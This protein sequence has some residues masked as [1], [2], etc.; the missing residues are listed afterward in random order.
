MDRALAIRATSARAIL[1]KGILAEYDDDLEKA[2]ECYEQASL[3][4]PADGGALAHLGGLRWSQDDKSLGLKLVE[5]AFVLSPTD[6]DI[7]ARFKDMATQA[8]KLDLL[9]RRLE[10]AS[11]FHPKH[12]GIASTLADVHAAVGNYRAAFDDL[13]RSLTNFD[14]EENVLQYGKELRQHL[15]TTPDKKRKPMLSVCMIVKNEERNLVRSLSSIEPI[16]DEIIVVDTGSIDRTKAVSAFFGAAIYETPWVD[17]FSAARN[18]SL[19]QARGQ[20]ILVLDADEVI[21]ESD[22]ETLRTI[23]GKKSTKKTAYMIQTRDYLAAEDGDAWKR[24]EGEYPEERGAGWIPGGKVRLFP[25]DSR[26]RFR[27]KVH[28]SVE[29]SLQDAEIPVKECSVVIHH[30]GRLDALAVPEK[31][32][33]S[34]EIARLKLKESGGKD[35]VLVSALARQEQESQQFEEA[36]PLWE[37]YATLRPSDVEGWLGTGICRSRLGKY[38]DAIPTLRKVLGIDPT[39]REGN[40]ELAQAYLHA[41]RTGDAVVLLEEYCD[42]EKTFHFAHIVLAA[43]YLC[44]GREAKAQRVMRL[45][46]EQGVA[47][48]QYLREL[49]N[50]FERE[51][52][53]SYAEALDSAVFLFQNTKRW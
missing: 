43:A 20:W 34:L 23:V 18:I 53:N 14:I 44:H 39:S 22:Y 37:Q 32:T 35:P 15:T 49:A 47:Y 29:E 11:V 9:A 51:G 6:L 33:R 2:A 36:L 17:D 7:L 19:D 27:N 8:G 5:R 3:E 50:A 12:R 38:V 52:K 40:V 13:K 26:I 28:E 30:Y 10:D 41:G 31:A 24:N 42:T 21:G 1:L 46:K 4:N 48:D 25:N 16:A 45:L